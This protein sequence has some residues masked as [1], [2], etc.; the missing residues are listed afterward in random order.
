M[1]LLCT[2]KALTECSQSAAPT[3]QP[4]QLQGSSCSQTT[5]I[6]P[7]DHCGL[8]SLL[9][10]GKSGFDPFRH[11]YVRGVLGQFSERIYIGHGI[12]QPEL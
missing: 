7:A 10:D 9:Q 5:G 8:C 3:P 4:S 1:A 2:D 6:L 11:S 12:L